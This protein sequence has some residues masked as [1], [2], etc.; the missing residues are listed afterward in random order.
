VLDEPT[1]DLDPAGR[2]QLVDLLAG[3][4]RTLLVVTHDLSFALELCP[5]SIVMNN[6]RV[7][8]GGA[9][10]DLLADAA[11]LAANRLELPYGF[12]PANVRR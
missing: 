10:D 11:L 7:V 1:S 5:R 9:T 8:A 6:G 2:R 3:L 12:H 4:E